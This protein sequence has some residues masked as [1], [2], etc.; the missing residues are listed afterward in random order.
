MQ[1]VKQPQWDVH[2]R[3]NQMLN[4]LVV[5]YHTL[6]GWFCLIPGG[7]EEKGWFDWMWGGSSSSSGGG[8]GGGGGGGDRKPKMKTIKDLPPPP[9]RAGG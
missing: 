2:H 6:T 7:S 1:K 5:S 9:R 3:C 4:F 8:G